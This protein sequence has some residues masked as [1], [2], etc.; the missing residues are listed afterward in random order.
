LLKK[1]CFQIP[2]SDR[3]A[4][5]MS[6]GYRVVWSG[7]YDKYNRALVDIELSAGRSAAQVLL[8]EGLAQGWPNVGNIWCGR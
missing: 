7:R 3:L 2:T 5:L 1:S 6:S 8:D 4:A